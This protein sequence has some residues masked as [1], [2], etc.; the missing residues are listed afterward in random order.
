M[1]PDIIAYL[2]MQGFHI[3]LLDDY[4]NSDT[5]EW[6]SLAPNGIEYDDLRT[7]NAS[8]FCRTLSELKRARGI[9]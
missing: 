6:V 2:E 8:V 3:A 4:F 9:R 1:R 7:E 5:G